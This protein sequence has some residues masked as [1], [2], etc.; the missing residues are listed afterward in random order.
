M[1]YNETI[2]KKVT[3]YFVTKFNCQPYGGHGWYKGICPTC[4]KLK[5]GFRISDFR[6]NCFY[7]GNMG[8]PLKLIMSLEDLD[9]LPQLYSYLRTFEGMEYWE[10]PAETKVDR[11]T[12]ALPESF[13]LI[14]LGKTLTSEY[15]RA[16]MKKR[17]FSPLSLSVLGI[18][19][20]SRGDYAGTIIFPFYRQNKLVYFI[21]RRFIA[22]AEN[23]FK[24]PNV[25]E[26]GIGKSE[27]IFNEDSLFIYSKIYI[28]ESVIN[29]LTIGPNAIAL[30]GKK[31]SSI[32]LTKLLR[33]PC[34]KF[35]ICLDDDARLEA[36]QL[37]FKLVETRK[38]KVLKFP[39]KR[40]VNDVG[41]KY[42]KEEDKKT[43]YQT[44]MELISLKNQIA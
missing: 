1:A 36:I 10:G 9:T 6:T 37:A 22:F 28:V 3:E 40:D 39:E 12:L 18:G 17:G 43:N 20:C 16:Y 26:L 32:Q 7:C 21:G 19:Y 2:K 27:L 11:T 42:V 29:A 25:D 15:A 24:N 5:F 13:K 4:D 8:N 14:S 34:K 44:H 38:V 23:K 31:I 30:L 35:V 33:S 41:K